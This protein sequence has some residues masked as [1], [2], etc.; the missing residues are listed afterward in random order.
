ML[1]FPPL[2]Q[3]KDPPALC[4]TSQISG[5]ASKTTTLGFALDAAWR[6]GRNVLIYENDRQDSLRAYGKVTRLAFPPSEDL[7]HEPLADVYTHGPFDTDLRKL[8]EK[9]TLFYDGAANAL[10]RHT[11]VFETLNVAGRLAARGRYCVI[12]VPVSARADLAREGLLVF[13]TWRALLPAPHMVVPVVF[14]RDGD[15][16]KVAAD[17]DLRR[18]VA[19]ASD[20]FITQPRIPMAVLIQHRRS[21]LKMCDLADARD[22][23]ATDA[24]AKRIGL[25]PT[26]VE[27]MRFNAAEMLRSLDPQFQKLGFTLGL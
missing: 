24:I 19:I 13:Q 12:F 25:D 7:V 16:S 17:H 14:H 27:M 1:E 22:P 23:L 9:T 5:G 20:G 18:L 11:Y 4:V 6:S 2:V 21:G 8:D 3:R 26:V 15:P 10:N